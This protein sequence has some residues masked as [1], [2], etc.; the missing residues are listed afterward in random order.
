M[1]EFEKRVYDIVRKVPE[2]KVIT[3]G[4][5]AEL[6]G[7]RNY[8][9]AVGNAMHKNPVPF[10]EL[11]KSAGYKEPCSSN[12]NN[13]KSPSFTENINIKPVPCHRV[14]D[15]SGKMGSNFGL[16][17]P[18]VQ[19]KMLEAEGVL[20]QNGKVDLKKF[21]CQEIELNGINK[22]SLCQ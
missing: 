3:Y 22:K 21:L 16:G 2:G 9:R 6:L 20:I 15:S 11:A 17:G 5:I 14:V 13:S 10:V 18:L 12:K 8:S 1:T 19:Q 4:R 7:S